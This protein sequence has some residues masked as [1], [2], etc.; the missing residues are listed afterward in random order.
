MVEAALGSPA[1]D[2]GPETVHT[3]EPINSDI[4]HEHLDDFNEDLVNREAQEHS[5][6]L[7]VNKAVIQIF[8]LYEGQ[9]IPRLAYF[10]GTEKKVELHPIK[11]H[12]L[13]FSF[14]SSSSAVR[15]SASFGKT[16]KKNFQSCTRWPTRTKQFSTFSIAWWSFP[17]RTPATGTRT[18]SITLPPGCT[19]AKASTQRTMPLL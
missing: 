9:R 8:E 16:R 19:P 18:T 1:P 5:Q 14:N 3:P 7:L 15:G 17:K 4:I 11:V 10:N 12:W 13:S 6:F 2:S